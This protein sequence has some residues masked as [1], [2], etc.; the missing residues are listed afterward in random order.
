MAAVTSAPAVR[1]R[2]HPAAVAGALTA[3]AFAAAAGAL[4]GPAWL[5]L[6]AWLLMGSA[7]G[8]ATSGST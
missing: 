6:A 2:W 3:A 5:G 7:A 8:Y 4:A 1:R